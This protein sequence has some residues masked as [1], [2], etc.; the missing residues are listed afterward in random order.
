ME[1]RGTYAHTDVYL[2]NICVIPKILYIVKHNSKKNYHVRAKTISEYNIL[3]IG[4][5]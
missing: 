5:I 3:I 1:T 4:K 2:I